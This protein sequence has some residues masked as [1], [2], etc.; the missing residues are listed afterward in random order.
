MP[1]DDRTHTPSSRPQV[2]PWAPEAV[3]GDTTTISACL[4]TLARNMWVLHD[5]SLLPGITEELFQPQQLQHQGAVTTTR[6]GRRTTYFLRFSG[7]DLVLRHYWRG[8]W[9]ARLSKDRY[10]WTGFSRT[11]P[12]KE[13]LLLRDLV[14]LQLPVPRPIAARVMRHGLRYSGDL[15]T[16]TIPES[17]PLDEQI[18]KKLDT[19][20]LWRR[21]G[22]TVARF[23]N[24]GAWHADLNVR[25]ILIG[26]DNE[27]WLIDW[28]RGRLGV[29]RGLEGNLE[30]LRRSLDKWPE[31]RERGRAGW[32]DLVG[33][34]Q[35]TR[36]L[37]DG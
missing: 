6:T 4:K 22:S 36:K 30:R 21:I 5:T 3:G 24:A 28:D 10:L 25:N 8:G 7:L 31:T 23:H 19:P 12:V 9:I 33:G 37:N 26:P 17:I 34:Y 35:E 20:V 1:D 11:R 2:Q 15:V 14:E 27:V 29:R 13:W 18:R 32:D 16:V